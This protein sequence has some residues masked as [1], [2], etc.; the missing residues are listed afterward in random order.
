MQALALMKEDPPAAGYGQ[1][2]DSP[3][4]SMDEEGHTDGRISL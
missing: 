3:Q 1:Q 2:T 4:F